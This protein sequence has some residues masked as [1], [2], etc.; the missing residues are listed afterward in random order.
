[1]IDFLYHKYQKNSYLL[2][3]CGILL[4]NDSTEIMKSIENNSIDFILTDP[5][6]YISK[7]VSLIRGSNKLKYKSKDIN[8]DIDEWDNIWLTRDDYK[9]YLFDLLKEFYRVLKSGQHCVIFCDKL[10]L[11]YLMES[12]EKIG[13]K[14][15]S[16]LF[17][18]KTNPVPRAR[19]IDFMNS[20]E[21]AVWLT[22]DIVK[23]DFFNW[24]LGSK[25]SDLI[26]HPIP[27]K[28]EC[29]IRHPTQKPIFVG[30]YLTSFLSKPNDV[31]LD[32]FGG[33][34]TFSLSAHLLNRRFI[35]IEKDYKYY[36]AGIG[37]FNKIDTIKSKYYN[38]FIEYM[39]EKMNSKYK[40]QFYY[41]LQCDELKI[42]SNSNTNSNTNS[43]D[44]KIN[45]KK[46]EQ[47]KILF[48]KED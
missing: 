35:G 21:S 46:F 44:R 10:I 3:D 23:S 36:N 25:H 18:R 12:G 20:I 31:C 42:I 34:F 4:N 28:E 24:Q 22:K 33:V 40:K 8:L 26:E 15:R 1:M 47:I 19:K 13:F 48:D 29:S 30:L 43:N 14:Y 9:R 11:G 32:P 5:P 39:K 41:L 38:K 6:Y 37:R 45:N 17:W 7:N 2:K 16:P 27:T